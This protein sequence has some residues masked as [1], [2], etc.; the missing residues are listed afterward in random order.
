MELYKWTPAAGLSSTTIANPVAK[1]VVTTVY[2]VAATD[3]LNCFPDTGYVTIVVFPVPQFK[4]LE[5]N[6]SGLPGTQLP[7]ATTSSAD[8]T[9][10]HWTPPVGLSCSN[11]PEPVLTVETSITYTAIARNDGF[12][13]AEDKITVTPICDQNSVFIPN[14]FSPNGDGKNDVFYPRDRG[15]SLVK[16]MRIFNRWGELLYDRKDFA[17]ND[18][19]AGWDGIYNGA[20]LTPDVY[21][22]LIDVVCDSKVVFN[23]KGNVTLL[24]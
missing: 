5:T 2:Q 20:K 16:S 11:C 12:C 23:I 10:W 17:L 15:A 13:K 3:S 21:V 18:P 9:S 22:Y 8:I 24:R 1:P 19:G 7:V 14:T 4:I 6:I